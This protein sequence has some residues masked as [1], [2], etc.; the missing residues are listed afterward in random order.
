[1]ISGILWRL[2]SGMPWR[3]PGNWNKA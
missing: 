3:S 2:R 1:M